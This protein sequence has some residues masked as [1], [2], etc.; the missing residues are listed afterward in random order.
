MAQALSELSRRYDRDVNDVCDMY[1]Q[2]LFLLGDLRRSFAAIAP[3]LIRF[4][5]IDS[6]I[7]RERVDAFIEQASGDN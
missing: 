7:L 1:E 3:G 2:G 4:P 5:S 6:E